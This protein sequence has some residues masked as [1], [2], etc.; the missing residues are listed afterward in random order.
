MNILQRFHR[1]AIST[2]AAFSKMYET[3]RVPVFRYIYSLMGGPAADAEDLTAETFIR[4][5]KARHSFEEEADSAIGWLIGISKRLVIDDHRRKTVRQTS[6][7]S[8]NLKAETTTEEEILV[9]QQKDELLALLKQLPDDQRE[10]LVLR[11]ML[12]WKVQQIASH[13]GP[14][15]NNVSVILHRT[16]ASLREKME[17][18]A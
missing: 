16:L 1:T 12:G 10:I 2:P 5:W 11:H 15:E 18:P 7:L 3:N 6:D 17:F 9:L 4:A 13:M 14:T 8:Y